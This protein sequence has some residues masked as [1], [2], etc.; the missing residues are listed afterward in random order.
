MEEKQ[1]FRFIQ[2]ENWGTKELIEKLEKDCVE[3]N[4]DIFNISVGWD[5]IHNFIMLS[6][7]RVSYG[8]I[9]SEDVVIMACYN[10]C[11]YYIDTH[12]DFYIELDNN[13]R[14]DEKDFVKFLEEVYEQY[15][16]YKSEEDN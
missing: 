4:S 8:F 11:V 10:R 9:Q 2:S 1:N 16:K 3:L 13:E 6:N 14:Y 5:L 12:Y 7:V 15:D